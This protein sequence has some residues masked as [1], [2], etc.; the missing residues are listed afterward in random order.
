[1]THRQNTEPVSHP[2]VRDCDH[3][4]P[5]RL[6]VMDYRDLRHSLARTRL[7]QIN[8]APPSQRVLSARFPGHR[9]M[10]WPSEH[11]TT[12]KAARKFRRNT[13]LRCVQIQNAPKR[14]KV[15]SDPRGRIK[16]NAA[17][18]ISRFPR[19]RSCRNMVASL[20]GPA[21]SSFGRAPRSRPRPRR[22]RNCRIHR[23]GPPPDS[24][25][26]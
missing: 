7:L 15:S 13:L 19:N 10:K 17:Q 16:R 9:P 20:L 6:S 5:S 8:Y 26:E 21:Y 14:G 22:R 24:R 23:N 25:I 3:R 12:G 4:D 18:A 1:M 11:A 2:P